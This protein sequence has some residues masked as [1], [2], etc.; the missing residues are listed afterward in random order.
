METPTLLGN[1]EVTADLVEIS[2]Y[3]PVPGHGVLA[4]NAFVIKGKEPVLI[5]TGLAVLHEPFLDAL[6]SVV[7]IDDIRWIWLSHLDADHVGNLISVLERAPH[8][9]VVTNFLG[10]GKMMLAGLPTDRAHLLDPGCRLVL[11]DR[12]LVPLRPPYY[13][14]PETMG[15]FDTRS[16]VLFAADAFGALLPAPAESAGAIADDVLRDGMIGWS[17][18]DA[19]WL[20]Q[21]DRGCFARSLSAVERLAPAALICGHLP[22]AAESVQRRLVGH[23]TAAYRAGPV[24]GPGREEI[25]RLIS[26]CRVPTAA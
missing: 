21:L 13:D 7:D 10:M 1:H 22:A 4:V 8:A 25:E 19:P 23:L 18:I 11:G 9:R 12:E 26:K 6:G 3:L 17:A 2:S 5:D 15:F 14:A 20:Q 24:D 16:R